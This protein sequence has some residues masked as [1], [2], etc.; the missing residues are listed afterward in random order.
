[1]MSHLDLKLDRVEANVK[2]LNSV[3]TL[4]QQSSAH[5]LIQQ[6]RLQHNDT[7]RTDRARKRWREGDMGED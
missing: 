2:M 4:H 6:A 5:N 7:L 3:D 1:M